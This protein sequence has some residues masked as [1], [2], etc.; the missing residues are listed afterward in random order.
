M[1]QL[2]NNKAAIFLSALILMT[3]AACKKNQDLLPDKPAVT[4]TKNG[5]DTATV[6]KAITL[7]PKLAA[8]TGVTYSWTVNGTQK[9]TD[10]TFTYTPD[11]R[12]DVQINFAATNAGGTTTSKYTIHVY[13]KYENGFFIANEGWFGHGTG[14][15][16]FYRYDTGTKEDSVFTKENPDKDLN[17]AT[18][19]VEF[20]TVFNDKIYLLTKAHGPLVAMDRYSLKETGRVAAASTSDWRAFVGLDNTHALVTSGSGIYPLDLSSMT[21][22]T[23]ISTIS[24][25]IGDI[26]KAG[27]YLFVISATQGLVVLNAADY[28]VV[29]TVA[30]IL[31]GFARTPDGS[32]W[33][34]GGTSL[35]KIDPATANVTTI[36][37]PFTVYGSWAAWHPGS[38]AA[39]TKENA[40]YL[41]KN[42]SFS[43]ATTIYKYTDGN[44]SSFTNPFITIDAGKELY[45]SGVGFDPVKNQVLVTTVKSGF[46]TNYAVD[47]LN[48][49]DA[50]TGALKK[51]L[52]YTGYYFPAQL[53]F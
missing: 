20:A 29:K 41:A 5:L 50:A 28:S 40:I 25:Q 1:K 36:T 39:S 35:L 45:G 16:S 23:K 12:G 32:V 15:L 37:V 8:K 52:S 31:V 38:I 49:Y 21:V 10:S 14:S 30:G 44:A 9:G 3:A 24:G 47:D 6:G 27:N 17:P 7:H 51:D 19:T 13:G 42:G 46:G 48:F 4:L 33:A 34:A 43:G 53:V 26:V 2:N 11:T 22:G 18:S